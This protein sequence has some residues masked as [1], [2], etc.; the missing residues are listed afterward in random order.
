MSLKK[1][2]AGL[3]LILVGTCLATAAHAATIKMRIVVVNPSATKTQTKSIKNFLP[4]EAQLRDVLDDGGLTLDYDAEQGLLFVSKDGI[5]LAPG[6]T[7]TFEVTIEDVWTVPEDKLEHLAKRTDNL[8][9]QLS[10]TSFFEQADLIGKTILGRL[11]EVRRT[12]ND[13]TV[14]R[15]QHIAYHR[16][17]LKILESVKID[18]E[19]LEKLVVTAGGPPSLDLIEE[20]DANLKAPSSKTT[21]IVIFIILTFISI[22]GGAFYFTWQGQ[23]RVTENIFT[24][25][26]DAS[27]SE[28][29]DPPK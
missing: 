16:D 18:I 28:F 23:A 17:N 27:F 21:W 11:E 3:T 8:L 14:S 26:K 7:K 15:Q 24:R 29:K 2:S 10:D 4:K 9:K 12:Q 6:E 13:A 5:E 25:E 1:I 22:L 19:K 20:S